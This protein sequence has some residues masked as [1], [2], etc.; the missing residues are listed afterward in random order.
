MEPAM[1]TLIGALGGVIITQYSNY[2]LESK[3]ASSNKDIKELE[4]KFKAKDEIHKEKRIAY[5]KFLEA[6]DCFERGNLDRVHQLV[7]SFYNASILADPETISILRQLFNITK[8]RTF[9]ESFDI[10]YFLNIK[11]KLFWQ[12]H[13]ELKK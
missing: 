12:M 9:D 10:E 2:I 7:S 1:Y 6:V 5:V 8:D 11:G 13:E 4:L 3:R